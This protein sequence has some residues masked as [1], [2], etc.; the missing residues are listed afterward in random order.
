M[1]KWAVAFLFIGLFCLSIGC[2]LVIAAV[3]AGTPIITGLTGMIFG[4]GVSSSL[5]S[6]VADND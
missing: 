2:V 4:I 1:N 6:I 5:I 3:Y